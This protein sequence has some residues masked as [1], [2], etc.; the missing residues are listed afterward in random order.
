MNSQRR[1]KKNSPIKKEPWK[2]VSKTIITNVEIIDF[3]QKQSV[4]GQ[5]QPKKA[6]IGEKVE[7]LHVEKDIAQK[8][9]DY[10]SRDRMRGWVKYFYRHYSKELGRTPEKLLLAL[11][12]LLNSKK[13]TRTLFLRE[14]ASECTIIFSLA[15]HEYPRPKPYMREKDK[16]IMDPD[17]NLLTKIV[18]ETEIQIAKRELRS[19][20]GRGFLRNFYR[21]PRSEIDY[22]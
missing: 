18:R 17:E 4:G 12:Y 10:L 14:D 15:N 13:V 2:I 19:S 6:R 7:F 5:I 1:T 9:L 22:F 20:L 8:I 11:D 3:G 16:I 21:R